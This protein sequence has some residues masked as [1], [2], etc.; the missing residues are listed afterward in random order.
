MTRRAGR[1]MKTLAALVTISAAALGGAA[2]AARAAAHPGA[3]RTTNSLTTSLSSSTASATRLETSTASPAPLAGA[4]GGGAAAPLIFLGVVSVL[5]A[6][7]VGRLSVRR[8]RRA[9]RPPPAPPASPPPAHTR[10]AAPPPLERTDVRSRAEPDQDAAKPYRIEEALRSAV[11][12]E[13][14][15]D[16]LAQ[17][18]REILER[19]AASSAAAVPSPS[20]GGDGAFRL[21]EK[22][23]ERG[24][25]DEAAAAWRLAASKQHAGAAARLAAVLE[26]TG[27]AEG[28]RA[29]RGGARDQDEP[30]PP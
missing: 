8:R 12:D 28:A 22:L 16:P 27:D 26:Q 13:L 2:G 23:Y 14:A 25:L 17:L 1:K 20:P 30:G 18:E 6:A 10:P 3:K 19:G 29:A 5:A 7:L 4:R 11:D 9:R 21:G 24:R 15:V